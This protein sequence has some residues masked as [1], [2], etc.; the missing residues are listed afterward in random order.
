MFDGVETGLAA[1]AAAPVA[2]DHGAADDL[3]VAYAG[4]AD[5]VSCR[6]LLRP[7]REV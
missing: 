6:L 7:L 2:A 1:V 5:T 4:P 3:L